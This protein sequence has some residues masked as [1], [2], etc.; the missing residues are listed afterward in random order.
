MG[1][2]R[3]VAAEYDDDEEPETEHLQ[4]STEVE[5][6]FQEPPK[7]QRVNIVS[8][9]VLNVFYGRH[10]VRPTLDTGATANMVRSSF[11]SHI[12]V[13]I[14]PAS[15]M[16]RQPDGVTPLSPGGLFEKRA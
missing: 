1:K 6:P 12:G 5:D 11:A 7:A 4:P 9:P 10:L 8:S 13:P 15:Q 2:S 14:S 16:A 3:Q